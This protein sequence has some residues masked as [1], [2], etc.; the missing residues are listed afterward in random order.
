[1]EN[2]CSFHSIDVERVALKMWTRAYGI[3]PDAKQ[4]GLVS[5]AEKRLTRNSADPLTKGA[6]I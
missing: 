2:I 5:I 3:V 1:L 6:G 4:G